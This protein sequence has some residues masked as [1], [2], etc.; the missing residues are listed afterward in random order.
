MTISTY[1]GTPSENGRRNLKRK[2]LD[3]QKTLDTM[4]Y[5]PKGASDM[6]A[7]GCGNG[8]IY[9]LDSSTA[10]V[11]RSLNNHRDHITV[12]AWSPNRLGTMLAAGMWA[13]GPPGIV[14]WQTAT[15][16]NSIYI[17]DSQTGKVKLYLSVDA[18]AMDVRGTF[19]IHPQLT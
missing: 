13:K 15:A 18:G 3:G 8:K 1:S 16:D 2:K 12:V 9:L 7:A 6:I 11:K 10:E 19:H 5:S 14:D 4:S 17:F